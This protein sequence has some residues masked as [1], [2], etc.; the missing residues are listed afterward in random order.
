MTQYDAE[1]VTQGV[2]ESAE[3]KSVTAKGR[4]TK[5]LEVSMVH[6]SLRKHDQTVVPSYY[7]FSLWGQDGAQWANELVAGMTIEVAGAIGARAYP[8]RDGTTGVQ[9]TIYDPEIRVLE[10]AAELPLDEGGW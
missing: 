1:Q 8:K 10:A 5:V 6:R 2:I 4:Q 7:R 9:L 3:V